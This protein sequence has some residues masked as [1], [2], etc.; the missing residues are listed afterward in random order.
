MKVNWDDYNQ[1]NGKIKNVPNH[2]PVADVYG[3]IW[4]P[5]KGN[6]K[7]TWSS[8]DGVEVLGFLFVYDLSSDFQ[9]KE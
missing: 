7:N 2:Q 3:N 8:L 6:N 4:Q 9:W 5:F 1:L